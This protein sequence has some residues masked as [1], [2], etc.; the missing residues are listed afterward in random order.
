[1][2]WTP[3]FRVPGP[4]VFSKRAAF[5]RRT[6]LKAL[7]SSI[8][9]LPLVDMLADSVAHAADGQPLK[10][11]GVYHPHGVAAEYWVM[12][13]G[14]TETSFDITYENCSLAPFDDPE[15]YGKSYKDKILVIEGIELMSSANGHDTAATILTGRR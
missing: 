13:D 4:P 14:D 3:A 8:V 2:K 7:G 6:F 9:A 5:E 15:T 10:F 12:Q 11:I 1:M